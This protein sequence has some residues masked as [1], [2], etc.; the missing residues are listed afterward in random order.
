MIIDATIIAQ[1]FAGEYKEKIYDI[2]SE[3]KTQNWTFIKFINDDYSE[4]CG[5]FRGFP[6]NVAISEKF[7][8]VLILTANFLFEINRNT[9]EIINFEEQPQYQNVISSPNGNYILIDYYNIFKVNKSI[10]NIEIVKS[11]IQMD[12]I[13]FKY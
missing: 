5:Q 7:N 3:W 1:P 9:N 8:T 11:K 2:E 12:M 4:W 6:K 10:S 13:E